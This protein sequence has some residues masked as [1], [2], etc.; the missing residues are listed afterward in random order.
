MLAYLSLGS[1]LGEREQTLNRAVELL[2]DRAG[3]ILRRS[4]FYYSKPWGFQSTNDFANICVALD[5]T[6][7]PQQLLIVTQD[8]EKELGRDKKT[9]TEGNRA[10]QDRTI[11]IDILLYED[12]ELHSPTLTIPH[13]L[14][15]QRDFVMIPLGEITTPNSH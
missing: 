10:Y 13:P 11:D 1:N 6:L 4:R 5:T 15:T 9:D 3:K 12:I 8:I 14:M 2:D 7:S